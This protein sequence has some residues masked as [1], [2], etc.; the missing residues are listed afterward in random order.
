VSRAA[1][2]TAERGQGGSA[3]PHPSLRARLL[4]GS[5]WVFAGK[6]GTALLAIAVNGLLA[7]L[8]RPGEFGTYLLLGSGAIIGSALATVGLDR[9]VVRLVAASWGRGEVGRARGAVGMVFRLGGVGVALVASLVAALLWS[10]PASDDA[11]GPITALLFAGWLTAL[12]MQVLVAESFR[13]FQDF[14]LATA[15]DG[16]IANACAVAALAVVWALPIAFRL[17]YALAV[18]AGSVGLSALAGGLA[19]RRRLAR[20]PPPEHIA[21]REVASVAWPFLVMTAASF[22]VA[23]GVDFWILG[24]VRGARDVSIYGAA[25]RLVWIVATPLIVV[26]QVVP[27]I[28]AELH[29]RG[30]RRQL[31]RSLRAVATVSGMPAAAL[32]LLFVTTGPFILGLVYG[33]F[34]RQGATV[35]A[36]LSFARLVAVYT[37]SSGAAL[38]MTGHQRTMMVLTLACG[39]A[40]VSLEVLL[41]WRFGMVGVALGSAAGQTAQNVAQVF[42]ARSR[43]GI[44]THADLRPAS[45]RSLAREAL[46]AAGRGRGRAG[47]PLV[48]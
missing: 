44:W 47:T 5:A 37:G 25:A 19:L 46:N 1:P 27:P 32:L 35:L 45:L 22:L 7:R 10:L 41:G 17:D 15:C 28:I 18:M 24:A 26:Q 29:A 11:V 30:A 16:L 21:G 6:M 9:A 14:R 48:P 42:V 8:L 39:V 2:G 34:Y 3:A 23:T 36:I 40:A 4:R 12:G 20:L 33:D 13:G 38:L 31:E 43:L